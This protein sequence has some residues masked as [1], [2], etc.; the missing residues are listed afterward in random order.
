M[1]YEIVICGN[2]ETLADGYVDW[3]SLTMRPDE[4]A[5]SIVDAGIRELRH[6]DRENAI[7]FTINSFF[8]DW[9]GGKCQRAGDRVGNNV[10]GYHN[11][12]VCTFDKNPP[13]W[14]RDMIDAIAAAMVDEAASIAG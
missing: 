12:W 2:A 3:D 11:G 13:L 4:Y 7:D 9:H 5:C 1:G 10:Y 8:A 6:R 14:L